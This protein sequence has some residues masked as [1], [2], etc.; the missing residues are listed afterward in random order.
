MALTVLVYQRTGSALLSAATFAI[1][2]LPWVVGGPV[3]AALADRFPRHRV[4]VTSDLVRAGLVGLMALPGMPLAGLLALLLAVSVAAPPFEAARSALRAD[5]FPDDRYAVANSLDSAVQQLA[6]LVGF[7]LGGA[8]VVWVDTTTALLLDAATFLLSA[9]WL[10][11]ALRRRPAPRADGTGSLWRQ[12]TEGMRLV[13]SSPRLVAIVA[14]LW[15][16]LL[17]VNAPEGIAT[18][19]SVELLGGTAAVGLVLA[20]NP[21]GAVVGSLVIGRLPARLREQLLV[22]LVVASLASL[23]AAGLL[24]RWIGGRPGL[25]LLV[26]LLVVSGLTSVWIVPLNTLFVHA[27]PAE[28]RGRAFGVAVAGL[29]GVQGLG[30]VLAGLGAEAAPPTWVVAVTG[31]LG[32][33]VALPPALA[34]R[35]T[36]SGTTA[37][38]AGPSEP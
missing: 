21:A 17:F 26:V 31:A 2:Y 27:V 1:S 37:A 25:V 20:A 16:G 11:A 18:P 7:L 29:Y 12:T 3:L 8:L 32:L 30:A 38:G 28:F 15:S 24:A 35:R 19:L 9:V 34:L 6:Q 4:L 14:L 10:A 33:L 36:R 13:R 5:V 23:L 22:P